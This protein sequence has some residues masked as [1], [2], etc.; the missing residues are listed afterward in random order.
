[1]DWSSISTVLLPEFIIIAGI[2]LALVSSLF[3]KTSRITGHI[4]T[5]TFII[6]TIICSR[7]I[8]DPASSAEILSGGFVSDSLS[9]YLRTLIYAVGAIIS[10]TSKRYLESLESPA[11]Y[12][13]LFMSATLAAGFLSGAHDFLTLFV[14]LETLSLSAILLVAYARKS[15]SSNEAGIKYLITSAVATSMFLLAVSFIYGMTGETNFTV[16]A[17]RLYQLMAFNAF[18]VPLQVLIA[19]LLA[20]SIGFKMAAAPFHNWAP[21]VYSGAPT[22]TTLFLSVISKIAA[23]AVAI[24]VFATVYHNEYTL[25]LLAI[26]AILSIIIGNYVG[27]IQIVNMGSIKRLLAY[28]SIAQSGYLLIALAVLRFESLSALLL[29]ITIYALMNT[30]AFACAISFEKY[31]GSDRIYDLSGIIKHK[32]GMTIIFAIA[33]FNLAGLP[34]I[35]A[36]FIAKFF[37]FA[38]A[39]Q[40]ELPYAALLVLIGLI[41]S[42]IALFYYLYTVKILAV[43]EESTLL[44]ETNKVA[45]NRFDYTKFGAVVSMAALLFVGIFGMDYLQNLTDLVIFTIGK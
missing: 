42:I 30:A 17:A 26:L 43:N 45:D 25:V 10:L 28:S 1:M 14:G 41:G 3:N 24:R 34:F 15:Q 6:A 32:P 4:A 35:P 27:I 37:L 18:S 23:F 22:N 38:S 19:C 5:I 11:E 20:G 13:P 2:F 12:Y 21:D 8:I 16:V 7:A 9:S 33:L 44:K 40:S 36:G 31:T 39:F 29:Y